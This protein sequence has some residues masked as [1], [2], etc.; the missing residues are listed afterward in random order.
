M[1]TDRTERAATAVAAAVSFM[2]Q[3]GRA[4]RYLQRHWPMPSG[5]CHACHQVFPCSIVGIAR[6]AR[7]LAAR[8]AHKGTRRLI[9]GVGDPAPVVGGTDALRGRAS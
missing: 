2:A 6:E 1:N 7:D 4:D 5:R 8:T 3:D 9:A